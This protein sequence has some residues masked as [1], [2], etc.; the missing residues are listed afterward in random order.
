VEQ[1]FLHRIACL[2][3]RMKIIGGLASPLALCRSSGESEA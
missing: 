1:K 2:Q 3:H